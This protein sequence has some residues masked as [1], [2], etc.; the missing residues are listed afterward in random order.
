MTP[1]SVPKEGGDEPGGACLL[2]KKGAGRDW[3]PEK[4]PQGKKGFFENVGRNPPWRGIRS[5]FFSS[6]LGKEGMI[7]LVGGN[8][9]FPFSGGTRPTV[10]P[11]SL[12][13]FPLFP[14]PRSRFFFSS[15][16]KPDFRA[17]VVSST[18]Y[19]EGASLFVT[20]SPPPPPPPPRERRPLLDRG[21]SAAK[22][23]FLRTSFS[24][25]GYE[26]TPQVFLF[27]FFDRELHTSLFSSGWTDLSQPFRGSGFPLFFGATHVR[28]GLPSLPAERDYFPFFS[29]AVRLVSS[30]SFSRMDGA[31]DVSP[32]VAGRVDEN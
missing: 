4:Q 2:S 31:T 7:S 12:F 16:G 15:A 10:F 27:F 28:V 19:F 29:F 6:S 3:G 5:A 23:C 13:C 25:F 20:N 24:R 21:Y 9:D 32:L 22:T 11:V 26:R 8:G 1:N 14:S 30:P 18:F 17:K